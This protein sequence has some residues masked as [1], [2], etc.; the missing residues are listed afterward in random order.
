MTF[1][2]AADAAVRK[3]KEWKGKERIEKNR[4]EKKHLTCSRYHPV[5]SVYNSKIWVPR[6]INKVI[7]K[8][9]ITCRSI[10]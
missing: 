9:T 1:Y 10:G 3:G 4:K 5:F 8:I 7:E 6:I 2:S